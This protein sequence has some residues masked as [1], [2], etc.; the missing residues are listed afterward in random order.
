VWGL[1]VTSAADQLR[2]M[3]A[4]VSTGSPLTAASR[5]YAL[6]LMGGVEAD[7]DWGVS[8]AADPGASTQLKN[9]WLNID[10]DDGLWAVNSVGLTTSGGDPM[11]LAVLSQHNPDYQTGVNRVQAGA[12]LLAGALN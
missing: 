3:R 1:S 12:K 5:Q 8:A 2:L 4:L 7:Q 6:Q 9:G 10:S 11:L